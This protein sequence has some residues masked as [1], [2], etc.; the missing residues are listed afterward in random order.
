MQWPLPEDLELET[1][2]KDFD[3]L[4]SDLFDEMKDWMIAHAISCAQVS[5]PSQMSKPKLS[6]TRNS[7]PL[8]IDSTSDYMPLAPHSRR[9]AFGSRLELS[10]SETS[11]PLTRRSDETFSSS[12]LISVLSISP[13]L[14]SHRLTS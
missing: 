14:P 13:L 4:L 12:V 3:A 1:Y 7:A 5:E 11:K 2:K 10:I 8:R 9:L 6:S